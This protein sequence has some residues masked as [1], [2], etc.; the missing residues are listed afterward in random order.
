MK[1]VLRGDVS[2]NSI[3]F[4]V[5]RDRWVF[6][7]R[8]GGIDERYVLEVGD[9]LDCGCV[10]YPAYPDT[11]CNITFEGRDAGQPRIPAADVP[12]HNER[13]MRLMR[14][15]V[16]LGKEPIDPDTETMSSDDLNEALDLHNEYLGSRPITP[17]KQREVDRKYRRAGRIINRCRVAN[18]FAES[19][20]N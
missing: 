12:A 5:K 9:L 8:P 15:Q 3:A 1:R 16:R 19:L 10:T 14:L 13:I 6:P 7:D 17:E 20:K 4:W 11:Y 2:G 18:E